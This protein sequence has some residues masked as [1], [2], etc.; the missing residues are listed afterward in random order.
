MHRYHFHMTSHDRG[1]EELVPNRSYF[2][3]ELGKAMVH[4]NVVHTA[5]DQ[6][7]QRVAWALSQI[8]VV[9]ENGF[10][11]AKEQE[12]WH[13]YYDI[14]TRNAF[15]SFRVILREISFSAPM[16][17]Y[18]TYRRSG[19]YAYSGTVPDENY[20]REVRTAPHAF[21]VLVYPHQIKDTRFK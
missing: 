2:D 5:Q 3:L 10:A 21:S 6:L 9:A 7:R 13:A 4:M 16:S 12:V 14:F 17:T 1:I 19:S 20:A 11:K 18:L 15:G 8:F